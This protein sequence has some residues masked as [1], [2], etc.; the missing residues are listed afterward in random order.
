MRKH[1]SVAPKIFIITGPSGVG[2]GTMIRELHSAGFR[3]SS[4]RYR[5]RRARPVPASVTASPITS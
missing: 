5:R 4:C 2:K 3:G 1:A